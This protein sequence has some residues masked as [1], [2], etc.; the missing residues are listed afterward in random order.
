MF[1]AWE[2]KLKEWLCKDFH[3]LGE[4]MMSGLFFDRP[5]E[6]LNDISIE[7]FTGLHDENGKEIYEGDIDSLYGNIYYDGEVGS[8]GFFVDGIGFVPMM[9]IKR[10]LII[11][12]IHE[13]PELLNAKP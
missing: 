11:G 9:D 7:Q 3:I 4:C 12:N 1:R 2:E 8:F 10:Y 5:L 13:N 6:R